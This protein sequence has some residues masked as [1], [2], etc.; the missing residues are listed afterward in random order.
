[1]SNNASPES[2]PHHKFKRS[3]QRAAGERS[4]VFFSFIGPLA[5]TFP[6]VRNTTAGKSAKSLST[7][8][9]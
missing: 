9:N 2:N 8:I 6:A 4:D 7:G 1:M 3:S 5:I